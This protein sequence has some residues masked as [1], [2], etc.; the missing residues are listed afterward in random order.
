MEKEIIAVHDFV[1]EYKNLIE[2]ERIAEIEAQINEIRSFS[3]FEREIFGRAI[4]DLKGFKAP[5]KFNL[6]FVKFGRS[7]EIETEIS[8]G[9]IVLISRGEPLKSDLTG[10]VSEVKSHFITVAFENMPPKWVYSGGIRIDLY[11]NDVTFK[12]MEENLEELR[13]AKGRKRELRNI[14][15]GLENPKPPKAKSFKPVNEKLNDSQRDALSNA[16]GSEDIFLIHGPPGT[17]KTSTLIEYIIQEIKNGKKILATAD[18]NTAVDNMLERL[19]KY[20][21]NVV[22]VG[23]PARILEELEE[24]SIHAIYEKRLEAVALKKG[25]EEVA[26]LAKRREEFSKPTQSR[27]RGL[28]H[29]RIITLAA[30]GKSMRGVSA[31]T[32]ASMAKWIKMDRKIDSLVE[33]LRADEEKI[34]ANIIK[35]ADVVLSTNSMVKSQVLNEF[36]FDIAVVDEGSQQIIPSTLIPL[37]HA[38]KFVIA[39]DHKQLPPTVVSK[40]ASKLEKSLFEMMMEQRGE[41]SKMLRVQYRMHENIMGFSNIEFYEGKLI[42]DESVKKHTLEDFKL[43]EAEIFKDIL[44]PSLPLVFVDTSKMDALESLPERS[45]SY[46][47]KT[48]ALIASKLVEELIDMGLD[49][50]QIGVISPYLSQVKRIKQLLREREIKTEVKSV[51]GFQGREK[52][53]II[54]SFVRSNK[55]GKI[56]FLKDI[57][58]LNVAITRA[59]RKLICIGNAETLNHHEVYKKFLNYIEKTENAE[60]CHLKEVLT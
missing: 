14:I 27:A 39:G 59:K 30:R 4:L 22:R 55:E 26:L 54:I 57:R 9:D 35:E 13:D 3:G 36:V 28:G 6:Y 25:W 32:L 56:G 34:Y 19:S 23:H 49:E 11:I 37:M 33:S 43:K 8:S 21:I 24:F 45:T 52:E 51:D 50:T 40:N 41:F 46:E 18:S 47:N 2:V 58:R 7:K 5:P 10:T 31:K 42:A 12:R 17:G 29:D 20:D 48:E 16:L 60:I 44:D 53:A 15:L 1:E 38:K